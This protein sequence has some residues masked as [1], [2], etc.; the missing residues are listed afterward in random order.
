MHVSKNVFDANSSKGTP[1][2]KT[3]RMRQYDTLRCLFEWSFSVLRKYQ[4]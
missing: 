3:K 1:I 4:A 2:T